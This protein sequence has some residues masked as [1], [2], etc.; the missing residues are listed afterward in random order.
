M[1][2][3]VGEISQKLIDLLGLTCSSGTPIYLGTSNIDHMKRKHPEAFNTYNKYISS[4]L[5]SP[6]YVR[7]AP[8]GSVEFVKEFKVNSEFVKLAVR[9]TGSSRW[10]L[11][12]M[13]VLNNNRVNNYIKKG[14]LLKY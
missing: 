10:Y 14:T 12:T 2:N 1:N 6:D 9:M 4:I 7:K 13:Y 5:S 3:K 11:R 8:D